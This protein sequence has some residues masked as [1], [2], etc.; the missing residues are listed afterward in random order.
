MFF[1]IHSPLLFDFYPDTQFMVVF[2]CVLFNDAVCYIT[3]TIAG[4]VS[5][6]RWCSDIGNSNLIP[7]TF[8]SPQIPHRPD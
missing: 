3:L 4:S 2:Q 8:C 5:M 1:L 6:E 7:V